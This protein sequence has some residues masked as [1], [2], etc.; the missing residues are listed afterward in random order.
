M[1]LLL[2][3]SDHQLHTTLA[4]LLHRA[5]YLFDSVTTAA[6]N[7][8]H[9]STIGAVMDSAMLE[10]IK[11]KPKITKATHAVSTATVCLREPDI[12]NTTFFLKV[13]SILT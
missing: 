10:N 12:K 11:L 9:S 2:A 4:H 8:Q 1:R 5:N 13:N 7:R 3:T 6:T